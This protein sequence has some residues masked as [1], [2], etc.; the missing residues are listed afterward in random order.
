MA[1]LVAVG[2]LVVGI[3]AP[4]GVANAGSSER[5]PASRSYVALGDSIPYGYSP[6]L[7][8]PW[9]VDRFVGYPEVIAKQAGLS[10]TN[11]A[12][13]G[14]TAQGVV[15]ANVSD[16]CFDGREQFESEGIPF[17][18]AQY[19]G[20]QL[21]AALATVRSKTPPSLITIQAGGNEVSNCVDENP[22]SMADGNAC[23]T[24][25]LPKVTK[26]LGRAS[27]RLRSAGFRGR[28]LLVGYHL[29]PGLEAPVR[30][31]N[32]AVKRAAEDGHVTFVDTATPFERYARRH[33][34]DLCA[35]G[36]LVAAPDGT[37]DLH[38]SPV[39]RKLLATTILSATR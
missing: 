13:P 5:T 30:R 21:D 11:L 29:P 36:L 23:I 31:L 7:E 9:L 20:T 1:A 18:H 39:G 28:L 27:A 2:L 6:R 8:D 4:T 25:A 14:Q 37:C 34:G 22:D 19:E 35:A 24:A 17:L 32:R 12:C 10:V 16:G 15:S 33:G 38:P 3:A 26:S